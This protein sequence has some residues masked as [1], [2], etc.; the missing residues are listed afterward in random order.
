M[1]EIQINCNQ[2]NGEGKVGLP[3][4]LQSTLS[5]IYKLGTPTTRD[6]INAARSKG[7][8]VAFTAMVNRLHRLA[9]LGL[10]EHGIADDPNYTSGR[11]QIF[12]WSA[13]PLVYEAIEE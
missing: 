3:S 6:L 7:E 1:S 4:I 2:C 9:A 12:I 10:I 11:R 5:D 13:V 8:D